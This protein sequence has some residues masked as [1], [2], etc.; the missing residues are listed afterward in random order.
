MASPPAEL[1]STVGL[2]LTVVTYQTSHQLEPNLE[3][4]QVAVVSSYLVFSQLMVERVDAVLR[5]TF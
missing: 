1:E 4:F 2:E 3:K 5:S